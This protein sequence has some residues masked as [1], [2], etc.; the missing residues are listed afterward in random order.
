[1][2]ILSLTLIGHIRL[3]YNQLERFHIEF[4]AIEQLILG[5]N[6]SGKS[7]LM[8]ELTPE[9][10]DQADY[11]KGGCKIICI[12]HHNK[13]YVLESNFGRRNAHSFVVDGE[14]L[15]EGGTITVQRD[16]VAYHF[17]ITREI[18]NLIQGRE[19][20]D[21]MRPDRRREWLTRFND[22]DQTYANEQYLKYRSLNS[23]AA[24]GMQFLKRKLVTELEKRVSVEER[25]QLEKAVDTLQKQLAEWVAL[26]EPSNTASETIR[27]RL[28]G[29]IADLDT[30]GRL[31]LKTPYIAPTYDSILK[32]VLPELTTINEITI[33]DYIVEIKQAIASQQSLFD[34]DVLEHDKLEESIQA[35]KQLTQSG[36]ADLH[37]VI[38]QLTEQITQLQ[39][40]R[41]FGLMF[42]D[43]ELALSSL[44]ACQQSLTD[45]SQALP[46][47][48]DKQQYGGKKLEFLE[49]LIQQ[50]SRLLLSTNERITEMEV[51]IKHLDQHLNQ[52]A[53]Q[54]P[55]CGHH[56]KLVP[57]QHEEYHRL[58]Q[59]LPMVRAE[60]KELQQ[61]LH[62]L[63]EKA[64]ANRQYIQTYRQ[65]LH[66]VK[67]SPALEP[68][69]SLLTE[70]EVLTA[71]PDQ[72]ITYVHQV[73]QDLMLERQIQAIQKTIAEKQQLVKQA[74]TI[75]QGSLDDQLK[76]Q[77]LIQQRVTQRQMV[78]VALRSYLTRYEE[79]RRLT[80]DGH[81]LRNTLCMLESEIEE[82]FKCW[83]DSEW[84]AF[85]Q[86]ETRLCSEQLAIK[87]KQLTEQQHQGRLIEELETQIKAAQIEE[88]ATRAVMEALSPKEGLIAEGMY[89]FIKH[90][91]DLMNQII[92][93]VWQYPLEVL[94]CQIDPES[95]V[96]LDYKFPLSVDTNEPVKDVALGSRS[97][98][99]IINL[100]FVAVA[101]L[102]LKL[103]DGPLYLDEF[104][105]G[106]DDAH[107]FESIAVIQNLMQ[108][109]GFTQLFMI[110]HY[111]MTYSAFPDAQ[112]CVLDKS[113]ITLPSHCVYNQHVQMDVIL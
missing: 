8:A 102:K 78:L 90:F 33:Q 77:Q 46:K 28:N 5:T 85:I 31:F 92:G 4:D 64:E 69:W 38:S 30:R 16:L 2:R 101:M 91:T 106:F 63:N 88:E 47:N 12:E 3:C 58:N 95:E 17:G 11:R 40:Q 67:T 74:S 19:T 44:N 65:Y 20:F 103:T 18:I 10:A 61:A 111:E 59:A 81:E 113:N 89:G 108:Q 99:E 68:F 29:M 72:L 80:Q 25:E 100:A 41:R 107:R 87:Q 23:Q 66:C 7:R 48:E 24:S 75:Q 55:E 94:P 57:K 14:E 54:C 76:R 105:S 84:Q 50:K 112:M 98:I 52:P 62:D 73:R 53:V 26:R 93:Q 27:S 36:Q 22:A 109:Y 43:S 104:G 51:R 83:V 9:P 13:A 71:Q 70:Y 45:V 86:Q 97:M 82:E 15:N 1:M 35:L 49:S 21:K 39:G 56:W 6:G 60:V 96:E 32:D 79:Y 37:Q 42:S 110:S 34:H